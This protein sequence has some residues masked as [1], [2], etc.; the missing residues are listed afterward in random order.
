MV[1]WREASLA[2]ETKRFVK[3][4]QDP[5][6]KPVGRWETARP[7][8]LAATRLRPIVT[9]GNQADPGAGDAST[10]HTS[11]S[12]SPRSA[13]SSKS[14]IKG[15]GKGND[16]KKKS[17]RGK[18]KGKGKGDEQDEP[19]K[20]EVPMELLC[21]CG[22]AVLPQ[23]AVE[24]ARE[25]AAAARQEAAADASHDSAVRLLGLGG[26]DAHDGT[27]SG[28]ASE[29]DG[30]SG[31]PVTSALLEPRTLSA[32]SSVRGS[33][34]RMLGAMGAQAGDGVTSVLA[35][36]G[37]SGPKADGVVGGDGVTS[38]AS[39]QGCAPVALAMREVSLFFSGP[40]ARAG[41]A[42]VISAGEINDGAGSGGQEDEEGKTGSASGA[43]GSVVDSRR[44]MEFAQKLAAGVL[45]SGSG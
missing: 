25:L 19:A 3:L 23:S 27:A 9:P 35:A 5:N 2:G 17:P 10:R 42:H 45:L 13:R 30:R 39:R 37:S 40:G 18:G 33:L 43:E 6:G 22:T 16:K 15:K 32:L 7:L 26:S 21:E 31:G 44:S 36:M 14:A 12:S 28:E 20:P 34:G 29:S 1:V 8:V 38:A 41:G 11:R 4:G 24:Q